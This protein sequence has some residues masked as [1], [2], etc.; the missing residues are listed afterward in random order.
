MLISSYYSSD[1]LVFKPEERLF[2]SENADEFYDRIRRS[3]EQNITHFDVVIDLQHIEMIP[4]SIIEEILKLRW[5]VAGADRSLSL[6]N[7][8]PRVQETLNSICISDI[9]CT[10]PATQPCHGTNLNWQWE[11]DGAT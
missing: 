1:D 4:I 3:I 11:P 10:S 5:W 2:N 9:L 8:R 7:V 6:A